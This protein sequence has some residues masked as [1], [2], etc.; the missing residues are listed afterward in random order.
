MS[1][2]GTTAVQVSPIPTESE[3][4]SIRQF[5]ANVA[6][7]LVNA[8]ELA[9]EVEDLRSKFN[10]LDHDYRVVMARNEELVQSLHEVRAQRDEAQ[11]STTE[12]K[13]ALHAAQNEATAN[14]NGW[15]RAKEDVA[16][17]EAELGKVKTD[18]DME[19]E[20]MLAAERRANE[21]EA[22]LAKIKSALGIVDPPKPEV[23]AKP[24]PTAET[25][26]VPHPE[27]TEPVVNPEPR[28]LT[29]EDSFSSVRDEATHSPSPE[30]WKSW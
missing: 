3:M 17:L 11:R 24:E 8:S 2:D 6:N 22:A 20:S 15:A 18:L 13:E 5:F 14:A 7:A 30:P 28:P 19:I 4:A 29:A 26:V 10:V 27:P 12:L 25:V 16:A 23:A 1:S 21:A 9:K